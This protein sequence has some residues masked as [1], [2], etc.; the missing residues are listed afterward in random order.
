[1]PHQHDPGRERSVVRECLEEGLYSAGK[2]IKVG[3]AAVA[4]A[5]LVCAQ[6]GRERSRNGPAAGPAGFGL[7]GV[8]EP[9]LRLEPGKGSEIRQQ[10]PAAEPGIGVW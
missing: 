1:M 8:A 3:A 2:G 7:D 6:D 5:R 10:E 4:V 9:V